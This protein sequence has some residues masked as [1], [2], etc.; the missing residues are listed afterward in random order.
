DISSHRRYGVQ[1]VERRRI[2]TTRRGGRRTS[3]R[4]LHA[5]AERNSRKSRA[6]Q[7]DVAGG[8]SNPARCV[9]GPRYFRFLALVV[10]GRREFDC[11]A[12]RLFAVGGSVSS[13]H[14]A[15]ALV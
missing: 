1:S 8:D 3:Q 12:A 10:V 13:V 11:R 15:L 5:A 2:A 7:S 4:A 14:S 9:H 6:L